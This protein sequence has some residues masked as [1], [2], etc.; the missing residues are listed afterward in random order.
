[1]LVLHVCGQFQNLRG[2]LKNL[3]DDSGGVK[4]T[5]DFRNELTQIVKRHEHLN[6]FAKRI[7]DSFNMLF[8]FQILSC[9]IQLCF[10]G[11]HVFNILINDDNGDESPTF[12]LIFLVIFITFIL[13]HLYIYCYVGEML[14]M[15]S[16][17]ISFSAY[18]SNW[19]N[20]PGKEAR[21]LL[22]IMSRST[23]PLSLTAG[24]LG[25][26]S[27]QLF[28]KIVKTSLG[29]LSVLLTVTKRKE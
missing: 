13:V 25:V 16:T 28:S 9:T 5:E 1:M 14:L 11:F 10:Q 17:E 27:L 7:E 15:Q 22:F 12:Q 24:K 19:Y 6:W 8:L 21:S 26:F 4:T 29:Y 3:V 18:E 20:V 23:V 2:R